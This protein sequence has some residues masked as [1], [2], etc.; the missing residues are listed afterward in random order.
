MI[1]SEKPHLCSRFKKASILPDSPEGVN[2]ARLFN[3]CKRSPGWQ[4]QSQSQSQYLRRWR[5]AALCYVCNRS[6]ACTAGQMSMSTCIAHSR[7]VPLMRS[8][9]CFLVQNFYNI[10]I[11][12][13]GDEY[14]QA[15]LLQATWQYFWLIAFEYFS[16]RRSQNELDLPDRNL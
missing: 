1:S 11:I 12:M 2:P 9:Q 14:Q 15:I 4:W 3:R 8:K 13:I 16:W 5:C 7:T 10:I 6:S